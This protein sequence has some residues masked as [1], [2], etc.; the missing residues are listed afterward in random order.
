MLAAFVFVLGQPFRALPH[1]FGRSARQKG[2]LEK[3]TLDQ[4]RRSNQPTSKGNLRW[5]TPPENANTHPASVRSQMIS[6]AASFAKTRELMKSKSPAIVAI[7]LAK[8]L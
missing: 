3:K 5:Q 4:L 2:K 7:R 6:I 1:L 8:F